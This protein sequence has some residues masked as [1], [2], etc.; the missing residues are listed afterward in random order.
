MCPKEETLI[1][2][3][4]FST[5]SSM[6]EEY[7][8]DLAVIGGGSGGL[9]CAKVRV[10]EREGERGSVCVCD[11]DRRMGVVTILAAM[12]VVTVVDYGLI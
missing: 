7:T 5:P 10:R 12:A 8:Y 9:A 11:D 4:S 6:G 1:I 3:F 2:S